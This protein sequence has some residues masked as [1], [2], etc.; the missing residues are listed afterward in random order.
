MGL[1][2]LSLALG[3]AGLVACSRGGAPAPSAG[4]GNADAH[5]VGRDACRSC[6]TET[7]STF[8]HTGM[9][10]SWYP[11][12]GAPVI[13]DWTQ[14][15]VFE[16]QATGLRYRMLRRDGKFFMRQSISDGRGGEAAVDER[17]LTWIVGSAHHSRTYLVTDGDKLF[18]AP[19]CWYTKDAAWD[20][21]PG[22]EFKND[23]FSREISHTCVFCHNAKME[24][25]P[26]AHNAYTAIPHGIDCE[27]CHGPGE[28]H[29]AKWSRGDTPTGEGDAAIVNPRRLTAERRMQ[30]CFQCHLGDS[31]ATERVQR[32]E[33]PLEDFRP[34]EAITDAMLPYRFS[35]ATPHDY[36]LS[37][38]ADRLLLSRCFRE[39]GGKLECVTCHDPHVTVYRADRPADFFTSKCKGCHG[40]D[41]CKAPAAARQATSPPDDCVL[42]H[43][44]K[45]T[46]DDHNHALFTDHWIRRKIDEA[47]AP[48]TDLSVEPYLPAAAAAL[49]AADRAYY[50]ARAISLRTFAVPPQMS[51]PMWPAAEAKFR[52]AIAQ[53]FADP[54]AHFFLGKSLAAEGHHDEAASEY[55]AAYAKDPGDYDVALAQAQAL[56]RKHQAD[57]AMK[58][59]SAAS[60]KDPDRAGAWAEMARARAGQGDYAGA[61]ALFA[62]AIRCEP[63]VAS[64]HANAAMM[65]SALE[66]HPDAIAEAETALRL[67]PE[68]PSTWEAYATLLER[69]GRPADAEVAKRRAKELAQARG[70]RM[71]DVRAM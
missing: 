56:L 22:Y 69:A 6:H 13:E 42:C 41:A 66:K 63:W 58:V 9:G 15:N 40:P 68:G 60:V 16:V 18:Q 59:L 3:L 29:V 48:R 70:R 65:L 5:Y 2:R 45:A 49:P 46:P 53:G 32:N 4:P 21:C 54:Q 10:L 20:L 27:R 12:A 1:G 17:E 34:G 11:V 33:K 38:Q 7:W 55:A 28:R 43:M 52:E 36:G 35:Q 61:S 47:P 44:R 71:N 39:S 31:K 19:V 24:L 50:L 51:R 64:L 37:A 67:D 26:G 62:R 57:E 23:Y 30:I 14:K 8:A 25:Q